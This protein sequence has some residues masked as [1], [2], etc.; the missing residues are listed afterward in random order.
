MEKVAGVVYKKNTFAS[1]D[2]AFHLAFYQTNR[3]TLDNFF[4][5]KLSIIIF[6]V[7]NWFTAK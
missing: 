5:M 1:K 3:P 4:L 6:S 7:I 2:F